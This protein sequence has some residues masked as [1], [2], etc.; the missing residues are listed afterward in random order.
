MSIVAGKASRAHLAAHAAAVVNAGRCHSALSWRLVPGIA[1]LLV[2]AVQNA[3]SFCPARTQKENRAMSTA[4]SSHTLLLVS[5]S[6]TASLSGSLLL[7]STQSADPSAQLC[8][9]LQPSPLMGVVSQDK[10][11]TAGLGRVAVKMSCVLSVVCST[12]ARTVATT[13]TVFLSD[14]RACCVPFRL[15]IIVSPSGRLS[16]SWIHR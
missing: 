3:W 11:L 1:D 6:V 4:V 13:V 8:A 16:V 7:G 2:H 9:L 14:S 10:F 12:A 5:V 15:K